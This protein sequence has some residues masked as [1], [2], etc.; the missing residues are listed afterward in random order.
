M[1]AEAG[2][3]RIAAE[4]MRRRGFYG[5]LAA[6][7]VS[8]SGSRLSMIALPWFVVSTTGDA[9]LTGVAAFAQMAPYVLAK[10]LAGP[11]IDEFGPRRVVVTCEIAAAFAV[12]LI[13][14][15]HGFGLLSFPVFCAMV[16]LVG[17]VSGPADGAKQAVI[18]AVAR[19]ARQPVERVTGLMGAIERSATTVGAAAAGAIV[20]WLGPLP[21]LYVTAGT[22]AVAAVIFLATISG[23]RTPTDEGYLARLAEG[24]AFIARDRLLRALYA[25]IAITNLL[26]A[27]LMSVALPLWAHQ[28]GHGPA[29][30]G[31]L[32]AVMG[33]GGVIA[34]LIAAAIGHRLPR[35]TTFVVAFLIAGAP[36]FL[37]LA[38]DVP[39]SAVVTVWAISGLASGVLNPI[40]GAVIFERIPAALVGRVTSLGTSLAWAGI[41]FGGLVGG[42]LIAGVGLSGGLVV[43]GAAFFVTTLLPVL[44]S[45]WH[46]M[47]RT[48]PAPPH[49]GDQR[50]GG[51]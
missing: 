39:L 4:P 12:L 38:A 20:A 18:P 51:R 2:P 36:Q 32:A 43:L 27:A 3:D 17:V 22:F 31:L 33:V 30:I 28:T 19:E 25:M 24:A 49:G 10:A 42:G 40:I 26:H 35:R 44:G 41:P 47:D 14:F 50:S 37:V 6:N 16:A 7:T 48:P 34:G 21:A 23:G 5:L 9:V 29:A 13:P 15:L 1:R 46:Q 45:A 11:L 8:L